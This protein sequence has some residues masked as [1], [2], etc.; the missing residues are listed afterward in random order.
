MRKVCLFTIVFVAFCSTNLLAGVSAGRLL[1]EKRDVQIWGTVGSITEIEGEVQETTRTFYDVSGRSEDQEDRENYSFKDFGMDGGYPTYGL[2][3]ENAAKYFTFHFGASFFEPD[4]SS[5]A[6]RNYYIG[7]DSIEFEGVEYEYMRIPEGQAFTVD[8]FAGIFEIRGMF[9][10]FTISAGNVAHFT[11]YV[12]FGLFVLASQYDIDAGPA[13]RIYTY[14]DPPEEFVENGQASGSLVG[15][16]PEIGLGGEFRFGAADTVNLVLRADY[17]GFQFSG[18]SGA[19][20]SSEHREK[21]VELDHSNVKVSCQIEM[22]MKS[23]RCFTLGV[24]W[25]NVETDASITS[26]E[27]TDEEVLDRHERFDKDAAFS[28]TAFTARAGLTF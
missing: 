11:P 20:T 3:F 13:T 19:F 5:V 9:T 10:P 14:L 21:D 2:A 25:I 18:D 1:Y 27:A 8:M 6:V 16:I 24:E 15:V 22:P 26:K 28:I 4:V 12:N 17:A 23:D 7:V